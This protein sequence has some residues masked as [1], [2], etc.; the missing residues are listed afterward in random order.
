MTRF[1]LVDLVDSF[2]NDLQAVSSELGVSV[3]EAGGSVDQQIASYFR[4]PFAK[5]NVQGS[6]PAMGKKGKEAAQRA[7]ENLC[8]KMQ[9]VNSMLKSGSSKTAAAGAANGRSPGKHRIRCGSDE[10]SPRKKRKALTSDAATEPLSPACWSPACGGAPGMAASKSESTLE[11]S[12]AALMAKSFFLSSASAELPPPRRPCGLAAAGAP[13]PRAGIDVGGGIETPP[14]MPPLFSTAAGGAANHHQQHSNQLSPPRLKTPG[15]NVSEKVKMFEV[16]SAVAVGQGPYPAEASGA[17][18][19]SGSF[20]LPQP[21][22]VAAPAASK[23]S[24]ARRTTTSS[25]ATS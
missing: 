13:P 4:A 19:R 11:S 25:T 3:R 17:R 23:A 14:T 1:P 24:A 9:Q 21:G 16:A 8:V 22:K 7:N 5:G 10:G 2:Q 18:S 6:G 20:E 12:S 15:K